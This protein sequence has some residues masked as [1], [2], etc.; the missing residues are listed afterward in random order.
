MEV[1]P[2]DDGLEG[3]AM[4][5]TEEGELNLPVLMIA[6]L[7]YESFRDENVTGN[8]YDS[9][10]CDALKTYAWNYDKELDIDSYGN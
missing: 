6:L 1:Y 10:P 3:F 2:G 7:F 8:V 5:K 4:M 9:N